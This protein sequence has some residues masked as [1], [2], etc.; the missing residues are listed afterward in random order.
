MRQ[1]EVVIKER[2]LK[3]LNETL[4]LKIVDI[5]SNFIYGP[6][7]ENPQRSGKK[8]DAPFAGDWSGRRGDY[9]VIY[10]ID[11]SN[12]VIYVLDIKH[13]AHAYATRFRRD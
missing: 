5:I 7:K 6:L 9:R 8:L 3:A 12:S 1:Y 11:D 2:A 4:P 10:R 13:R